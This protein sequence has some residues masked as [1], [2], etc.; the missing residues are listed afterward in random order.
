MQLRALDYTF[1]LEVLD[2]KNILVLGQSG[3]EVL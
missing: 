1:L 2:F 3:V